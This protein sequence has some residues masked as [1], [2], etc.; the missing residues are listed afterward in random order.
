MLSPAAGVS[1]DCGDLLASDLSNVGV[2]L[3]TEQCWDDQLMAKVGAALLCRWLAPSACQCS[4]LVV[5][6]LRNTQA[7]VHGRQALLAWVRLHAL[8]QW[9]PWLHIHR[10]ISLQACQL[11]VQQHHSLSCASNNMLNSILAAAATAVPGCC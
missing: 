3:L 8:C 2:L 6:F 10:H 11:A 7:H 4:H 5:V 9:P 1:F